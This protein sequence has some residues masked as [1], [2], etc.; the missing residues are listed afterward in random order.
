MCENLNMLYLE[1]DIKYQRWRYGVEKCLNYKFEHDSRD[2][3]VLMGLESGKLLLI[4]NL[5]KLITIS[6]YLFRSAN[7]S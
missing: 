3:C 5:I 1:R 4:Y 6:F 7:I 2:M